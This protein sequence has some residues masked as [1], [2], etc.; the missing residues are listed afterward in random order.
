MNLPR[1]GTR[2]RAILR[3]FIGKRM[4]LDELI[5]SYGMFKLECRSTLAC[6]LKELRQLGYLMSNSVGWWLT[7]EAEQAL[8]AEGEE[9]GQI[10]PPRRYNVYDA[11][12]LNPRYYPK[13]PHRRANPLDQ[14]VRRHYTASD[15]I[16]FSEDE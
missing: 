15:A 2:R 5:A 8:L 3:A 9:G 6:Q 7:E 4:S 10:V 16:P 11:P 13:N 12:P 1:S 14:A